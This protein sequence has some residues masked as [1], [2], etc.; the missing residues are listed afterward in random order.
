MGPISQSNWRYRSVVDPYEKSDLLNDPTPERPYN[1]GRIIS[2]L[3]V[4]WSTWSAVRLAETTEG[5][6]TDGLPEITT[7]QLEK[8]MATLVYSHM[9]HSGILFGLPY[10]PSMRQGDHAADGLDQILP[11]DNDNKLCHDISN[12]VARTIV[13]AEVR[14]LLEDWKQ[15]WKKDIEEN[16]V[17][18]VAKYWPGESRLGLGDIHRYNVN[19]FFNR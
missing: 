4:C 15:R 13:D 6:C 19:Y 16:G 7:G 18:V 12:K 3:G 14:H 9:T 10:L 8:D 5:R 11:M 1:P 17:Q 2:S